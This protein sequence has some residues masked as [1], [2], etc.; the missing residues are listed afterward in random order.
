MNM[1]VGILCEVIHQV[2]GLEK[3][4]AMV[5]QLKKRLLEVVDCFDG[6]DDDSI[7]KQEFQLLI[8]NPELRSILKLV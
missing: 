2:S 6:D 4:Q 5:S 7:D 3:E 8:Q 1:L